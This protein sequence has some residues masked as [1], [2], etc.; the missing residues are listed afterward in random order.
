MLRELLVRGEH[1]GLTEADKEVYETPEGMLS[2]ERIPAGVYVPEVVV[3]KNV[4]KPRGRMRVRGGRG[5][6][7]PVRR[8]RHRGWVRRWRRG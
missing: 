1:D 2:S 3:N 8:R 7:E 4:K 6:G 5:F